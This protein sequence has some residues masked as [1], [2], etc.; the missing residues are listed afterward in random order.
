MKIV[1]F[2]DGAYENLL[3]MTY[4]RASFE[5]RIG[6]K[7]FLENIVERLKPEKT[8]L[9]ARDYLRGV[10]GERYPWARVDEEVLDE[11]LVVNGLLYLGDMEYRAL[12]GLLVKENDK[13]LFLG[14]RLVAVKLS[15]KTLRREGLNIIYHPRLLRKYVKT[16]YVNGLR[17]I[18]YPWHIINYFPQIIRE[19]FPIGMGESFTIDGR[20]YVR[21]DESL[22][23]LGENT[24]VEPSTVIDVRDGPVFIGSNVEIESSSRISGPAYIGD[25]SIVYGARIESSIIGEE[26]RIGGEVAYSIIHGHSNKRH[27]GF[28]GHSYVG[29]WVNLGAG[30]TNSNLKNTYGEV[31]MNIGGEEVKTGNTFLGCFIGDH[32]RASIG[33]LVYT[34]KKIGIASHIHGIIIDDVPPFT[35]YAKSLG[36]GLI[37]L[38]IERVL[39]SVKK[40]MARRGAPL[41]P[42]EEDL[43]R[44]IYEKTSIE[45][46]VFEAKRGEISFRKS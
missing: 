4:M 11:I 36:L 3:P 19:E 46:E 5:L 18:E 33:T 32:V 40:M 24:V 45:R 1:V 44:R 9:L 6:S 8:I 29:E 15:E 22:L 43:L 17:L 35:F 7:T 20:V 37:E 41:K 39:K 10:L 27:Y 13:A 42:A 38:E 30:F 28:L 12:E 23:Y 16:E 2:E 25:K 31:R 34:A 14:E 26:C 21:G